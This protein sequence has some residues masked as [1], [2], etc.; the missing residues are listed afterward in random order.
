MSDAVAFR[1][2]RMHSR[3]HDPRQGFEPTTVESEVR[4]D[5]LTG[6]TGRICHF[7]FETAPP[8]DFEQI[9]EASRSNCPFC[10]DK[11]MEVTP[12]FEA[13][14]VPEGRLVHGDAVL[15]PNMFPYD[16]NSAV[17]IASSQHFVPMDAMPSAPVADGIGA[18]REFVALAEKA[19]SD[20]SAPAYGLLTWNYMPPSGGSMV[21]PH[22]QVIHTTRPGNTLRRQLDAEGAWRERHGG[23]YAEALVKAEEKAGDRWI[24]WEGDV[25]WLTPF[26][27]SGLLG[28]CMAVFPG[29]A[30]LADL[31]ADQVESFARSLPRALRYFASRGVWSFN[32]VFY[33]DAEGAEPERHWLT[34]RVLPRLYVNPALHVTDVAYMQL[35][36]DERFSMILPERT[37]EGLR[38]AFAE[39][40]A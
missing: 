7:A 35:M 5:P 25:A 28:D 20:R 19:R 9:V 26:V 24:G 33:P 34:A 30:T 4:F 1:T 8:A 36:L 32:L 40:G 21:H 18:A 16:D 15:V 38:A 12:R 23:S 39:G 37:A 2:E 29:C 13:E 10:P 3:F 14:L 11:V 27:P 22:M 17:C 31:G 6:D